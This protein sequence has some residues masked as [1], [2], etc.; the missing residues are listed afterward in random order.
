MNLI[1]EVVREAL[2]TGYL[3]LEAEDKLRSLLKNQYDI[4][5]FEAFMNLQ[6]AARE[7]QVKQESR[8][9]RVAPPCPR[10]G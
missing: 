3:S 5:D 6:Q 7:G 1:R 9:S 4:E 10:I 8:E 2:A